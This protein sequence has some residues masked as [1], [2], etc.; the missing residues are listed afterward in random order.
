MEEFEFSNFNKLDVK[1]GDI[2]VLK[3][4]RSLPEIAIKGIKG[5]LKRMFEKL[6]IKIGEVLILDDEM[7]IGI[8]RKS[9]EVIS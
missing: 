4:K 3:I 7:D 6:D 2:L 9:Q 1:D 5:Q 8:L